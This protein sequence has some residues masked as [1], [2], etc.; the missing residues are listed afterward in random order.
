MAKAGESE[1]RP[2]DVLG[3]TSYLIARVHHAL[4]V[5]I[6]GLLKEEGVTPIQYVI[7]TLLYHRT[8]LSSAELAREFYVTPQAMGQMLGILEA[9]GFVSRTENPS[10]RRLLYV[11]LTPSGEALTKM[12][13][14]KIGKIESAAFK[15]VDPAVLSQM[16]ETLVLVDNELRRVSSEE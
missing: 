16:R 14:K 10:N 6:E 15:N 7:M 12:C 11:A 4:R 9:R 5:Q 2:N 3:R 1:L 13:H 8:G